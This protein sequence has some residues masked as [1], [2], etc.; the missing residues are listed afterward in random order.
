VDCRPNVCAL[1]SGFL[2]GLAKPERD[3]IVAAGTLRN[4]R[5]NSVVT[6][7]GYP[8]E[9]LFLLVKGRARF[10]QITEEGKKLIL[11]WLTPGDIFGGRS[12]LL[13]RS[14]YLVSTE[15]VKES[16]VMVWNRSTIRGLAMRYPR[17]LDNAI[18]VA[19]DFIASHLA[20]YVALTSDNAR[21]RL[22]HVLTTCATHWT[23]SCRP[24]EVDV[25][26]EEL[27]HAANVTH[28]TVSRLLSELQRKGTL[29]K[30]RGK[31][32]LRSP[33][34]SGS[35]RAARLERVYEPSG[36]ARHASG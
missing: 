26:N 22:N 27:A 17:L 10:F 15:T 31:L 19:S 5:A 4:F 11:H 30:R 21:N 28:F 9:D 32:L 23:T 20:S 1:A 34:Q 16:W 8:A 6:E 33:E 14:K 24:I 36:A 12:L 13:T 2:E 35:H 7:Q 29:L 3:S 18:L 25:T